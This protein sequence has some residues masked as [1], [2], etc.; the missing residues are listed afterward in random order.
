MVIPLVMKSEEAIKQ[1]GQT[2]SLLFIDGDHVYEG[3]KKDFILWEPWVIKGGM[4]AFHDKYLAGLSYH[5]GPAKVI[6]NHVLKSSTFG[7]IL[8]VGEILL[9]IKGVENTFLDKL[10]KFKHLLLS[11]T[12]ILVNITTQPKGLRW[13]RRLLGKLGRLI[14]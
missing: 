6:R 4:I 13:L 8:V 2:I 14:P 11:Y 3:V 12:A 5:G 7:R 10:T 9:A 1:W